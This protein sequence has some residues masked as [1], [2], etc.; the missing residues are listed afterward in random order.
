MNL[1]ELKL[2]VFYGSEESNLVKDFFVPVFENTFRAKRAVGYFRSSFLND[3]SKGLGKF[4]KN[5]GKLQII[6]STDLTEEDLEQ[7]EKGYSLRDVISKRIHESCEFNESEV[8][9][10]RLNYLAHLIA[11][12]SLDL[13]VAVIK[14]SN[15][16]IFHEKWGIYEDCYGNCISTNG[17]NNDTYNAL[18]NNYESFDVNFSWKAVTDKKR[19]DLK[20]KRFDELWEQSNES[21]EVL[22]F[23]NSVIEKI[24]SYRKENLINEEDLLKKEDIERVFNSVIE[25]KSDYE[26]GP[27]LPKWF[28]PRSYQ[29]D[30]EKC[31]VENDRHGI[32]NMATGTGKTLTALYSLTRLYEEKEKLFVVIVCPY[33]HLVEQ[34]VEDLVDFDIN[35]IIGYS[36]SIQK[37]WKER[38]RRSIRQFNRGKS[39]FAC[40]I[41]SNATF[42]KD[43]TQSYLSNISS[44]TLLIVDEAH[45]FGTKKRLA[46]LTDNYEYRLALSATINRK[47]DFEGT[48]AL[49]LYFGGV[50]FTISID[51]AINKYNALVKYDYFIELCFMDDYE[52]SRYMYLTKEIAK[53]SRKL[54]DGRIRL[55]K[56]AEIK[57]SERAR[58]VA[59]LSS[60][61]SK[62]RS[63]DELILNTKNNLIYCGAARYEEDQVEN[64]EVETTRQVNVICDLYRSLGVNIVKFTADENINTRMKV[65]EMFAEGKLSTIAAIKCLDEGVN[66]PSIERAFILASSKDEKQYIQRRG[67]ILRKFEKGSYTKKK[68]YLYD[69]VALPFYVDESK[70]QDELNVGK[71]LVCS[72]LSR[73]KEFA[74]CAENLSQIQKII[75]E[76]M[77][78][79]DI[80][81]EEFNE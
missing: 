59:T 39:D 36:S 6:T 51:E 10:E 28:L 1:K 34:W 35:P 72:E 63:Y 74:S 11:N 76:L 44:N 12:G 75:H 40:F 25:E 33:Q 49:K 45:N 61:L 67:R 50:V 62:L 52:F 42:L 32:Y 81:G 60:K 68:A 27:K 19:I 48:E 65:K 30:A 70:T 37:D 54:K 21:I 46:A 15:K 78:D 57:A 20:K 55:N 56:L 2:N 22:E 38:L 5:N 43:Y 7:I 9:T 64:I 3:I 73:M 69:F 23:P 26:V 66:I 31:W 14:N 17:S 4:V 29:E 16:G 41:T 18:H 71:S 13:K 79:Y 53:N 58:L 80:K 8:G 24:K 77:L 47:Y